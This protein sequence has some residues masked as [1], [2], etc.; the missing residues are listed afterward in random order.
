MTRINVIQICVCVHP[1]LA[2]SGLYDSIKPPLWGVSVPGHDLLLHLL[3]EAAHLL[4]QRQ[5]VLVAKLG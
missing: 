5:H 2:D 4:C 1:C 3:C